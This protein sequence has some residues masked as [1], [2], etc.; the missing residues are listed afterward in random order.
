MAGLYF[1]YHFPLA[2]KTLIERLLGADRFNPGKV[3]LIPEGGIRE[4]FSQPRMSTSPK[5][6]VHTTRFKL[7]LSISEIGAEFVRTPTRAEFWYQDRSNNWKQIMDKNMQPVVSNISGSEAWSWYQSHSHVYPIVAKA[8]QV[9]FSRTGDPY[10]TTPYVVGMRNLLIKR[11]VYERN[12]AMMHLEEEQDPMGNVITKYL[13]D[14]DA[15]KAIDQDANTYW[16]SAPQPDPAAVVSMYLDTRND[17]GGSQSFDKLYIDP[18]GA[19]Q[20]LN[21][22]FSNDDRVPSRRLSPI[23]LVPQRDENTQWRMGEGRWDISGGSSN[24]PSAYKVKVDQGPHPLTPVWVGIEWTPDFDPLDGNEVPSLTPVLYEV[25][26]HHRSDSWSPSLTYDPGAGSFIVTFT[27]EG[28]AS[29]PIRISAGMNKVFEK[30]EPLRIIFGWTYNPKTFTLLVQNKQ[31]EIIAT[32][33]ASASVPD[34]VNLHGTHGFRAFRGKISAFVLKLDEDYHDQIEPFFNNPTIYTSPEPLLPN[35]EG[36]VPSSSLDNAVLSADFTQ[37][38]MPTGGTDSSEFEG[39]E[40]TPVWRNYVVEKGYLQ[41][42]QTINCRYLKLEFTNLNAEPYPIYESGIDVRYRVYPLS[43]QQLASVGPKLSVGSN[44]GGLLG[45]ANLNGVKTINWL[46]PWSVLSGA[47]AVFGTQYDVVHVNQSASYTTST[48][49]HLRDSSITKSRRLE[50]SSNFVYRREIIDPY[51]LARNEYHTI[52]K[53]EGLQKL[54]PYTNIPWQDIAAA[55]PGAISTKNVAG[56][57][58]V[59]GTDWWIF[60]GQELRIPAQVM[61]KLTSGS[62]VLESKAT[63]ESRV[64]FTT[65]AVHR[66]DVRTVRRDSAIAYFAGVREVIPMISSYIYGQDREVFDF[67]F[68]SP[69]QWSYTAISTAP[70]GAISRD[71]SVSSES[72]GRAVFALQTHSTFARLKVDFR[73]AGLLRSNA[74]WAS[75]ESENLTP[76]VTIIPEKF[77]ANWIDAF[78]A[79]NDSEKEWG[80][81]RGVVSINVDDNRQYQGNRVLRFHR[82][83]GSGEAG[84]AINQKINF[85][86]G[87]L[88]RI[89]L[90]FYKPFDNDNII[91]LRL[92]RKSGTQKVYEVPLQPS[93]GSWIDFTTEFFELPDDIE[94]GEEFQVQAVLMGDDEDELYVANLY[95]EIS[96]VRYFV[97]LGDASGYLHD[98]TE[99]RY[100]EDT[101]TYVTSPQP[102]TQ[103][104]ITTAILS[105]R[106]FAFGVTAEPH[107]LK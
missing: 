103:A 76:E 4:W 30:G 70:S 21:V 68:Y 29:A 71:M 98:V 7:P 12:Q 58:P 61:N 8:V 11:N 33:T 5:V 107:F 27:H 39:K 95:T 72:M 104:Q 100:R 105:D 6:E 82:A 49:P 59:R 14:W 34:N 84:I 80:S 86:A 3:P 77:S 65:T 15:Q 44:V 102:V 106:G 32:T 35:D 85:V 31:K 25:T 20:H 54:Q 43:V 74:M 42:P 36:V 56:T 46:N 37:Q 19:G 45:V 55:N 69:E 78:A 38:E 10:W 17:D 26:C 81:P 2:L 89:G 52:I 101:E 90:S 40:W 22:Y 62:V 64:R 99:L 51:V 96:H 63:L 13:K 16:R 87:G 93:Y 91:V 66:Y 57:L 60:P 41:F 48:L 18:V 94:P 9:R 67:P 23:A 73:D 47:Q 83:Q 24:M 92:I 79:W 97:R 1:E 88:A 50:L 75:S 28:E 53:A